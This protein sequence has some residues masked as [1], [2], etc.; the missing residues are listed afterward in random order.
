MQLHSVVFAV[1]INRF[2]NEVNRYFP[3]SATVDKSAK[4]LWPQSVQLIIRNQY[5][6]DLVA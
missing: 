1:H 5:L 6:I 4:T 2:D 3:H